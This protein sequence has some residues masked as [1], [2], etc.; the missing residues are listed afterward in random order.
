MPEPVR[1]LDVAA[2][3]GVSIATVSLALRDSALLPA[4]TKIKVRTLAEKM[5]YRV[6]PYVSAFMSWRRKRGAL[7]KPTIALLHGYRNERGWEK[8]PSS[9]LRAMHRGVMEL[10]HR[11]GY[12]AGEFRIGAVRAERLVTILQA[13]GI[14]G[15]IFAPIINAAERYD[16]PWQDFSA[17]QIGTG[18]SGLRL[19]RVAHDH[20]QGALE[21]VR[22][23]V[24]AGCRR[25]GLVI[26]PEHDAR[27]QHVWR[28]GFE[29]GLE[30]CGLARGRVFPLREVEPDLDGLQAW[31]QRRKPDVIITNLHQLIEKLLGQFRVAVPRDVR[32]VSLSVPAPGD[33]VS[34]INQ[35][36]H[37]IGTQAVDFLASALQ[38][39]RTGELPQAITTLVGG[40]WNSGETL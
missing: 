5:G 11:R 30:E 31:F 8:H 27:L 2:R 19:P 24:A 37:L 38:S 22:R 32:L 23:C 3:A 20:Y 15:L 16:F 12:A 10:I 4:A 13:R 1:L 36:G 39:H 25:P 29:M 33:R 34:G 21:A 18:P 14:S 7:R 9:T 28:A 35:D 17:V 40:Q 6:H 26:D